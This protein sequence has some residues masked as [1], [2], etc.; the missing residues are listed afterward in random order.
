MLNKIL[1]FIYA[2]P[3]MQ[4]HN[5]RRLKFAL[6]A[7]GYDNCC[8]FKAS[9]EQF[10]LNFLAKQYPVNL[11][12][13]IGANK[14]EY[15]QIILSAMPTAQVIAFE[16]QPIACESLKKIQSEFKNRLTI[17]NKAVGEKPSYMD[18]FYR[19]KASGLA[20]FYKENASGLTHLNNKTIKDTTNINDLHK[21]A[22]INRLKKIKV[23]V[24]TLDSFVT[25]KEFKFKPKEI[26]LI[27]IDT[28]G[29]E[30]EV[31][32]G[33]K[34]II[35]KIRPKFI[36]IEHNRHHL[37]K[38]QSLYMHALLMTGYT[39]YQLLKYGMQKINPLSSESNFFHYSNFVFVRNDISI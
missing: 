22:K 8:D 4:R 27:K 31:L 35:S 24:V 36:Q 9:G 38:N 2:R 10:F 14:G 18:L 20:S 1:H 29:Y 6:R 33:M 30:Y 25:S 16:P 7:R 39:P 11:C 19:E 15:T 3:S 5:N 21:I 34:K 17:V 13:D 28:E 26:D 37:F 23:K 32:L 12:I